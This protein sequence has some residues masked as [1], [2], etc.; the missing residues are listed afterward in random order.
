MT[1]R[2][3]CI[4][5]ETSCS[6]REY[7]LSICCNNICQKKTYY[8]RF[9]IGYKGIKKAHDIFIFH[10]ST[11]YLIFSDLNSS[12][13]KNLTLKKPRFYLRI[14]ITIQNVFVSK[15]QSQKWKKWSYFLWRCG[16]VLKWATTNSVGP[17]A[18]I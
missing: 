6:T 5:R 15:L 13:P 12:F 11:K 1:L 8:N 16:S 17:S 7:A 14:S 3:Y 4:L 18:V 9:I 2:F 10:I